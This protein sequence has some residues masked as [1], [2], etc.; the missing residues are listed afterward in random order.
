MAKFSIRIRNKRRD[1]FYPVYIGVFHNQPRFR[2]RKILNESPYIF[3][4]RLFLQK[5]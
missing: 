5:K 3:L 2:D 4:K 1:G